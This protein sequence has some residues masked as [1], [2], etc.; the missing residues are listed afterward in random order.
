M[1]SEEKQK[2]KTI[3]MILAVFKGNGSKQTIVQLAP[4]QNKS[5]KSIQNVPSKAHKIIEGKT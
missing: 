2:K 5:V 1:G 3:F 4:Q